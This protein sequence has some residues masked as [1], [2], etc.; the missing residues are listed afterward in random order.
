VA[1]AVRYSPESGHVRRNGPRVIQSRDQ[2]ARTL[3]FA[4]RMS[5]FSVALRYKADIA[6]C[7]AYLAES[8][9]HILQGNEIPGERPKI[10]RH[11][12]LN[13]ALNDREG[14]DPLDRSLG[15]FRRGRA[16]L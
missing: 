12:P 5:A 13:L 11:K 16:S 10:K 14:K 15:P 2:H 7:G 4:G 8:G 1:V 9:H 3:P 6:F